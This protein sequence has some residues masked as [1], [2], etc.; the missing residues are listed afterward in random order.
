MP[1]LST[2]TISN[3]GETDDVILY[4]ITSD[5]KQFIPTLRHKVVCVS[6][7]LCRNSQSS[8][9]DYAE[10]K[11]DHTGCIPPSYSGHC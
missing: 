7:R 4:T 5:S 10:S 9:G 11:R 3:T 6:Y 8:A 2:I 1:A